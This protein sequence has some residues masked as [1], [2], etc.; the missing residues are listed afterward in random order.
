MVVALVSAHWRVG[1][2]VFRPDQ[3][4][5]YVLVLAVVAVTVGTVGPGKWSLDKAFGI[6]DSGYQ[7][8]WWGLVLSAALGVV[9]ALGQLAVCW[10]PPAHSFAFGSATRKK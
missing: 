4:I 7:T 3:G 9:G 10:K 2:F 8:T 5:E 1:F 6:V